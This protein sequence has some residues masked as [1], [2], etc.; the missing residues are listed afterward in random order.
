MDDKNAIEITT[1]V[2]PHIF[3]IVFKR[4]INERTKLENFLQKEKHILQKAHVIHGF[5]IVIDN[6]VC[7]RAL[8]KGFVK[9]T[10]KYECWLLDY[11]KILMTEEVYDVPRD[12]ASQPALT[13]SA[14]A[15]PAC[16]YNIVP[17]KN[18][19]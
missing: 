16:L 8:V 17:M 18:V 14:F 9:E 7:K 4:N 19:S 13:Q 6:L 2:N 1:Y 15:L 10:G 11:G 5:A 12:F 3:W